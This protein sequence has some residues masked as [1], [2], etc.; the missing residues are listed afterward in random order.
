MSTPTPTNCDV[1]G[2]EMTLY[3]N[4]GDDETPVWVE[5]LGITG[6]LTMNEVEDDEE[7]TSR[8]RDRNVKEY[9]T[10]ETDLNIVG[11]QI[12]DPDYQ[13]WQYLYSARTHGSPIDVMVLTSPMDTIGSVGWRGMMLNKDR[14]FNGPQT[15]A[16]TQNF[17]LRPA[18]CSAVPVRPVKVTDV[19]VVG[20]YDPTIV[21]A[22]S[23]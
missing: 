20:D 5:H 12:M 14:T 6:D 7:L 23:S 18:A 10:G 17:S 16:Q 21:E 3:Y 22:L 8:N 13:G 1:R 15:G 19:D 9:I 2:M 4:T 11:T